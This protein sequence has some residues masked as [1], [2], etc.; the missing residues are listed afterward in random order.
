MAK[1]AEEV[2]RTV[3]RPAQLVGGLVRDAV[4]SR[5][6]LIAENA[7]LRQQL[8]V[9]ARTVK[10]PRSTANERGLFLILGRLVPR[11][12]EALLLVK[13]DTLLRSAFLADS[14][15]TTCSPSSLVPR[16]IR[17]IMRRTSK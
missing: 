6:E 17:P 13:P 1:R 8:L 11:W 14:P 4:R 7:L 15:W 2:M 16:P 9:A 3:A 12:R 10:E 5:D